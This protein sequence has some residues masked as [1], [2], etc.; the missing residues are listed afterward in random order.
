MTRLKKK[1]TVK[2]TNKHSSSLLPKV[3]GLVFICMIGYLLLTRLSNVQLNGVKKQQKPF[4]SKV[5]IAETYDS[6]ATQ[7]RDAQLLGPVS[8][9]GS[10]IHEYDYY[11]VRTIYVSQ[12]PRYLNDCY[13]S[14][15]S[16]P[17]SLVECKDQ[18]NK[19]W[20]LKLP[21]VVRPE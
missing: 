14:T 20:Y 21:K 13:I 8:F 9:P 3:V 16:N 19:P 11:L 6:T 7:E 17:T 10:A 4:H 1:K 15:H 5:Q 2:R 12:K 18:F